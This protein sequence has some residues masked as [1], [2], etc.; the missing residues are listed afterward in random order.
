MA[1]RILI[2]D[3]DPLLVDVLQRALQSEGYDVE[4]AL[5][6]AAALALFPR[7]Q[8]DLVILDL[9]MPG[10]DGFAVLEQIRRAYTVPILVLSAR[11]TTAIKVQALNEGADDYVVKP[12]AFDEL[13]ARMN[14]L[15]R[16][17]AYTVP[18]NQTQPRR[19]GP[20]CIDPQRRAVTLGK[21][22]LRLT[23]TEYALL[24]ELATHPDQVL[25]HHT[26][27]QRVW[28]TE[29]GSE[30][31]YLHVY[32]QRLRAKIEEDPANPRYIV[33]EPGVGYRFCAEA[34]STS[35]PKTEE[36]QYMENVAQSGSAT[37]V[38]RRLPSQA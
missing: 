4:V 19:F 16:R 36:N 38:S 1:H 34:Y 23:P 13:V 10:V 3:D 8:P 6:G 27:L 28:G 9:M 26:L 32:I 24:L 12:F 2:V 5:N 18:D 17:A 37:R 35:D 11:H 33:T 29:Y 22:R 14:A 30:T 15:L 31:H 25:L 7:V 21:D 20:L